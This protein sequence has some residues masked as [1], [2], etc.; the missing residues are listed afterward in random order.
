MPE[1]LKERAESPEVN[2][3]GAAAQVCDTMVWLPD[4]KQTGQNWGIIR[5]TGSDL[6]AGVVS[7]GWSAG[8]LLILVDLEEWRHISLGSGDAQT[9]Q[10]ASFLLEDL[11][12]DTLIPFYGSTQT[13]MKKVWVTNKDDRPI[14][15]SVLPKARLR[16]R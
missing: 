16:G 3:V 11:T 2:G 10:M 7:D 8:K 12:K 1:I 4:L 13:P 5:K 15:S 14:I 9:L 6:G